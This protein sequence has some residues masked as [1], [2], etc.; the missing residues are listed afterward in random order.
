MLPE[1]AEVFRG[2]WWSGQYDRQGEPV[3]SSPDLR[4]LMRDVWLPACLIANW[5][6]DRNVGI[7]PWLASRVGDEGDARSKPAATMPS[8]RPTL[9]SDAVTPNI[10]PSDK[11]VRHSMR[12]RVEEHPDDKPAPNEED[13]WAAVRAHF[14]NGLTQREFRLL[15]KQE[16][17]PA[18]RKQGRRKPGGRQRKLSIGSVDISPRNQ[19]NSFGVTKC[20]CVFNSTRTENIAMN[21]PSP[22]CP[23]CR[24]GA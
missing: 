9:Q 7:P 16:T 15:R 10:A 14:G 19:T 17:P 2:I 4:E 12:Q 23:H 24:S 5:C 20:P 13:D 8:A 21:V 6:R 3:L 11:A 1:Q 22:N 18:W